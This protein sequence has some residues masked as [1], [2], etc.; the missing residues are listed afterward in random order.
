MKIGL[1]A[2]HSFPIPYKTH[3]GDT[4]ITDLGR[5]LVELGHQ[6]NLY[7]PTGTICP[8]AQ[9]KPIRAAYG[10]FPPSPEQCEQEC[11]DDYLYLLNKE[12]II[13]DFSINKR[14]SENFFGANKNNCISTLLGGVWTHP[15]PPLNIVVWTE[16]MRLRGIRGGTDYENTPT[17]NAD[18]REFSSI[19]DAHVVHGGIDTQYYFPTYNK[20]SYF[21]WMNRWHRAKGYHIAIQLARETGIELV[22]AG[23]H[24]NDELM[25]HQK[26]CALEAL[27]LAKDLPNIKFKWLLPDPLHHESKRKLYQEAKA[28]LYT[29][30]F[31]EPFGLSQVESLACGTPVIGINFGSV[32]EVIDDS[33]TGYVCENNM[34]SLLSA[35]Q[36]IN[37]IRPEI[38]RE[39]AV[40]K[41][42]RFTMAKN[43]LHQYN[44]VLNGNGWGR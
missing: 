31:Q 20:K 28:L 41:Y 14:V 27:E 38:C 24:P 9:I 1:I 17:P 25:E 40:K 18:M 37:M 7:A 13:H 30:Q 34:T 19:K 35:I 32:S 39:I 2:T 4:V 26:N 3:T 44:E 42:D 8:G 16:A 12:D 15:N 11:Y 36:K 10:K 43:Y 23:T 5:T 33:I 22:M 21:L 6:V 29:V